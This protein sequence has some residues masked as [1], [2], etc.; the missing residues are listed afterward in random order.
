MTM[1]ESRPSSV[2]R[3]RRVRHSCRRAAVE[4]TA[5]ALRRTLRRRVV[6]DRQSADCSSTSCRWRRGRRGR[7][8][9][10]RRHR[11]DRGH[12]EERRYDAVRPRTRSMD[13]ATQMGDPQARRRPDVQITGRGRDG[14]GDG[15][16]LDD[17]ATRPIGF[18]RARDPGR[19]A[20]K[21]VPDLATAFRRVEE[22]SY[23]IEDAKIQPRSAAQRDQQ[24]VVL[25][26]EIVPA[27]SRVI[28]V[29]EPVGV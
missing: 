27:E 15:R 4:R 29:R 19:R 18:V 8:D 6:A 21:I 3:Q 25:N 16:R 2:C 10:P 28:L 23:P 1:T 7:I 9:D 5:G 14:D 12:R 20:Q 26:A 22:Y 17:G 11:R 13:R 24:A